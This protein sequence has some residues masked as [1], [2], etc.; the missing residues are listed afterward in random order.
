MAKGNG[1][2][3]EAIAP[4]VLKR[5][6]A[7]GQQP[8]IWTIDLTH[9]A[10]TGIS[11]AAAGAITALP[12][13]PEARWLAAF[14][15]SYRPVVDRE[16]ELQWIAGLP[17]GM[18]VPLTDNTL[19][20]CKAHWA[21]R[22]KSSP[23]TIDT[24]AEYTKWLLDSKNGIAGR[25]RKPTLTLDQAEIR[26]PRILPD[27]IVVLSL[28]SRPD[29]WAALNESIKTSSILSRVSVERYRARLPAEMIVPDDWRWVDTMYA[30]GMDHRDIIER[31]Y[32]ADDE[33]VL[34]L[35]DDAI[36][37]EGFDT[38]YM[39]ACRSLPADWMGLWLTSDGHKQAP[40]PIAPGLVRCNRQAMLHAYMLNR[41]GMHRVWHH[42]VT[43]WRQIVDG[44]TE[45]LHGMEPH[46][47]ATET[48]AVRQFGCRFKGE[49]QEFFDEFGKP[50]TGTKPAGADHDQA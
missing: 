42:L 22:I 19:C 7:T 13:S 3:L 12:P 34:I 26:Y 27:R 17:N 21:E 1:R 49:R 28:D 47:Y 25:L 44:A 38:A 41:R 5:T 29:R 20:G 23:P 30:T 43:C 48:N 39:L 14:Q 32:V 10:W 16:A 18:V 46:F 4:A 35:E 40:T 50:P 9:E 36:I 8:E 33:H 15:R 11:K 24:P 6:P 45:E 37:Q 31:S 2:S